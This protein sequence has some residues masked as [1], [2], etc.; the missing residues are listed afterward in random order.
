MDPKVIVTG[1]D[2]EERN[3]EGDECQRSYEKLKWCVSCSLLEGKYGAL[4]TRAIAPS[5]GASGTSGDLRTA[6]D[7]AGD[8]IVGH[9]SPTET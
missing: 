5:L 3:E 9:F 8:A 1:I 6:G 2:Q 7:R 4:F